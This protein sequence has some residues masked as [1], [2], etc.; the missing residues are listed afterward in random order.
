MSL[1]GSHI[2][3][4]KYCYCCIDIADAVIII[5]DIVNIVSIVEFHHK[6]R[7][8]SIMEMICFATCSKSLLLIRYEQ[9]V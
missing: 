6:K 5:I 2:N 3:V 9:V 8:F 4:V 1:P 7:H